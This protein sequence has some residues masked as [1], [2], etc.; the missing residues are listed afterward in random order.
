MG[1]KVDLVPTATSLVIKELKEPPRDRKKVKNILH[2]G[3]ITK[4]TLFSIARQMRFKSQS[5]EFKGTVKEMLGTC[6]AVGCTIDGEQPASLQQQIDDGEL[7]C[8]EE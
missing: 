1:A 2:D 6:R 4:D 3:N 5:R 7:V 8:P